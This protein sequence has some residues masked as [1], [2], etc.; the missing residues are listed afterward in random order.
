MNLAASGALL[1]C[2]DSHAKDAAP[3][4]ATLFIEVLETHISP[5]KLAVLLLLV[6][7]WHLVAAREEHN[8]M[9]AENLSTCSFA[10]V[11]AKADMN[12]AKADMKYS[13][14]EILATI[15]S[16][17]SASK[18][19][20]K[21]AA[22]GVGVEAAVME[23]EVNAAVHVEVETA[24]HVEVETAAMH[25]EVETAAVHVEVEASSPCV[26]AEA[27]S[28]SMEVEA[29]PT[30]MEVEAATTSAEVKA[31]PT[32]AEVEAASASVEVKAASASVEAASASVEA[33]SANVE[34]ASAN[35]EVKAASASAEMETSSLSVE[36]ETA[37]TG[38]EAEA[39]EQPS[40]RA[41][42][43]AAA[44]KAEEVEVLMDHYT[45]RVDETAKV[46]RRASLSG[47]V[48]AKPAQDVAHTEATEATQL[49]TT[50]QAA[51]LQEEVAAASAEAASVDGELCE[52][53][54]RMSAERKDRIMALF[55]CFDADGNGV[56]DVV[57]SVVQQW[58]VVRQQCGVRSVRQ[59]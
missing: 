35:V 13:L 1:E 39:A 51:E 34:A 52:Q 30:S 26:K 41:V 50:A 43:L 18:S 59:H 14:Q 36:V 5:N 16:E 42:Q 46:M 3:A 48:V 10:M 37:P 15:I 31:A 20:V 2:L 12:L 7:H 57:R 19:P 11:F 28:T 4:P 33:A 55:Q 44:A 29:A 38:V 21:A 27:A 54:A 56:I 22:M 47:T 53:G 6:E 45:Q 32:S 58:C 23:V 25:V 40:P 49:E 17:H 24:M 8:R 9:N